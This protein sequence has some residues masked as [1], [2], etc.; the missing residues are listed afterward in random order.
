M[1]AEGPPGTTGDD[2]KTSPEEFVKRIKEEVQRRQLI[3]Q[4][5]HQRFIQKAN[6][7]KDPF[8]RDVAETIAAI[9][10][11]LTN[12]YRDLLTLYTM[13]V[14][15]NQETRLLYKLILMLPEVLNDPELQKRLQEKVDGVH[16]HINE[17]EKE[18]N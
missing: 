12:M 2:E 10:L 14:T 4:Q 9:E 15:N 6:N 3:A 7:E 18:L 16:T 13:Q 1:M 11:N 8:R 5:T 17:L